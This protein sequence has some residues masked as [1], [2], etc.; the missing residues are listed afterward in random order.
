MASQGK[1]NGKS[2]RDSGV[3]RTLERLQPDQAALLLRRLLEAGSA[4]SLLLRVCGF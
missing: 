1:R 3:R 2:A 4:D